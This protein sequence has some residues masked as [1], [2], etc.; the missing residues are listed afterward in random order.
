MLL[1]YLFGQT[2][3]PELQLRVWNTRILCQYL[4]SGSFEKIAPRNTRILRQHL[5]SGSFDKIA[6]TA[7]VQWEPGTLVVLPNCNI[8]ANCFCVFHS[9][10]SDNV[11][12][13]LK[14]ADFLLKHGRL[15]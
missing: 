4:I 5:I 7:Q 6:P 13:P 1:E 9:K 11:E 2:N 10:C 12:L 3:V 14:N 15:F 8:N